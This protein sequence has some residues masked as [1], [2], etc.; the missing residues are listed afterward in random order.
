MDK[1]RLARIERRENYFNEQREI[2]NRLNKFKAATNKLKVKAQ[3]KKPL[4]K[5]KKEK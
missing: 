4:S 2:R 5:E 1:K 3:K